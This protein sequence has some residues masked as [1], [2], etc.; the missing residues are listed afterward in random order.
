MEKSEYIIIHLHY[1]T[2]CIHYKVFQRIFSIIKINETVRLKILYS[3][4]SVT[5]Q[6]LYVYVFLYVDIT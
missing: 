5:S 2:V 3:V 1:G 6:V 4:I